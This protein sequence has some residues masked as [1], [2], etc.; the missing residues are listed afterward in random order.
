VSLYMC[1]LPPR[2]LEAFLNRFHSLKRFVYLGSTVKRGDGSIPV[3]IVNGL[4][5]S[6]ESLQE[7]CLGTDNRHL[8]DNTKEPAIRCLSAFNNL[9][10]LDIDVEYWMRIGRGS[11][12]NSWRDT[13]YITLHAK[14]PQYGT[15]P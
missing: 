4:E 7:L 11:E 13:G 12:F 10:V 5:K 15:H 3:A 8:L 1:D 14:A 9:R 2:L 6:K